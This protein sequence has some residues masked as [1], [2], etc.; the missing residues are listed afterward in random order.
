MG[1][2]ASIRCPTGTS[3]AGT[4]SLRLGSPAR[5]SLIRRPR[6]IRLTPPTETALQQE[7]WWSASPNARADGIWQSG[8]ALSTDGTNLYFAIG[9]GFNGPN[10]AFDPANGNYSESGLKLSPAGAGTSM[11]VV[12]YF[13]PFD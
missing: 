4:L 13:T 2:A 1:Q 8:G 3:V 12:D 7:K 10:Q 5:P 11:T 6:P 9:N